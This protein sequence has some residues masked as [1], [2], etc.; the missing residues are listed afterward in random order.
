MVGYLLGLPS[1]AFRPT[2]Q[3]ALTMLDAAE[4]SM[5]EALP[6]TAATLNRILVW[7]LAPVAGEDTQYSQ[8][9]AS[10]PRQGAAFLSL[11]RARDWGGVALD[12]EQAKELLRWGYSEARKLVRTNEEIIDRISNRMEQMQGSV[13]DCVA[14][15]DGRM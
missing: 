11:L 1:F 13:G 6:P 2:V 15:I 5:K 10:D 9:L 14:I 7:L 4:P 3:E 12:E 8:L